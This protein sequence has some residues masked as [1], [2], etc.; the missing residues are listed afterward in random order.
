MFSIRTRSGVDGACRL[1]CIWGYD[2]AGRFARIGSGGWRGS[3]GRLRWVVVVE[4]WR[5][6]WIGREL[7][8]ELELELELVVEAE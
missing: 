4:D 8:R 3:R 5:S 2:G 1:D 7:V 6:R